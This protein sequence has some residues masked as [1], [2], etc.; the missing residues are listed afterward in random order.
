MALTGSTIPTRGPLMPLLALG[1]LGLA[2]VVWFVPIPRPKL[3]PVQPVVAPAPATE[4]EQ[5]PEAVAAAE[6][7]SELTPNFESLR[8]KAPEVAVV[9]GEEPEQPIAP[10]QVT[11]PPLDWHYRGSITGPG[12]V[13]ALVATPS[14]QKFVF[15]G[16]LLRDDSNPGGPKVSIL[17]IT[18][19]FILVKRGDDEE[20]INHEVI[21]TS[22]SDRAMNAGT[23]T[24]YDGTIQPGGPAEMEKLR[25]KNR[26]K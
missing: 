4:T 24:P 23:I 9:T 16:Q 19:E 14:G 18:P 26:P 2:V 11:T 12:G 8:E 17:E 7:W 1:A 22:P 10:P 20:Q 15:V 6:D 3:K 21:A 13:A 25:R 5:P